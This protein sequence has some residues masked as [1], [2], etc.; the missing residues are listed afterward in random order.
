MAHDPVHE[1]GGRW[2]FWDETWGTRHGP[3]PTETAARSELRSY[4]R[5]LETR[6][7]TMTENKPAAPKPKTTPRVAPLSVEPVHGWGFRVITAR[8][9]EVACFPQYTQARDLVDH[10]NECFAQAHQAP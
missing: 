10:L 3:Y 7:T 6:R 2:W 8:G 4:G 1:A 5:L 9:R